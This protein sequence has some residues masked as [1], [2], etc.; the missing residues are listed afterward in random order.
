[1]KTFLLSG[2]AIFFISLVAIGQKNAVPPSEITRAVYF[3]ISEPLRDFKTLT[4]E[5]LKQLKNDKHKMRNKTLQNRYYPYASIA[6]PKGPD[7]VWQKKMGD[8]VTGKGPIL[9]FNGQSTSSTPPDCNGDVGPNHYFQGVNSSYTIY[10]KTGTIVAGPSAYNSLFSGVPGSNNNDGDPIIL[11]DDQADRWMAAEFSGAY[12]NPDYMLI[13][14]STTGDPTGTWYRWSFIMQGFPDYMKF[15]IWQ[16]GYY[17]ATN[18]FSGNDVYVFEREVMLEG[19]ATPQKVGFNNP[20]RPTTLDG[21]HCIQ[22]LDND[23]VYAPDGSPGMFITTN[24]DAIGGGSDQL[25]IYELDV[26]WSS[27]NSSTF[28]RVQQLNVAAF[29]SNFGGSWNNILQQGTNQK[30]DAIPQILMYR[31]QYRNFGDSQT[32]VCCQ[33][34]DVDQSNHA[35][36]RWYELEKNGNDWSVRQQST[37]GP[38][39][40]S[41]WMGSIAINEN[42]EIAIGYSISS[43]SKYPGIR[44]VGQSA[45]ANALA[46]G[47]MDVEEVVIHEGTES[48]TNANR[49]GDYSL[50]TVDP[51]D[52][53]FWFTTQYIQGSKKTK[54]C[55]FDLLALQMPEAYAG[56]D[57]TICEDVLLEV[58]TA[59]AL[60]SNSVEWETDG[61]GFFQNANVINAKYLRGNGDIANGGVTLTLKVYGYEAGWEDS[62]DIYVTILTNP[63]ANAGSD[64]TIHMNHSAYLHGEP[65]D[66]SMVEWT[67]AGDG[68]FADANSLVTT[69]SPGSEDISNQSAQLT[70]NVT[71]ME[72]CEG[73]DSDY[74]TITID[75]TVGIEKQNLDLSSFSIIPNPSNGIFKIDIGKTDFE[76]LL[77]SVSN[78]TGSIVIEEL[79]TS[80]NIHQKKFDISGF[81]KGIYL[82]ELKTENY[83]LVK[84]III[85]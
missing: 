11:Y 59:S 69:Y 43:G 26:N 85:K 42:H 37:Y 52:N 38:D 12:S 66:Y 54:I 30:L 83:N 9:N 17:M 23:G 56:N 50:L 61:D 6:L 74:V 24:D 28:T 84:K 34:V 7:N 81:P 21:F 72:P 46:N 8:I 64:T 31:A 49:W 77:I 48:Q 76:P 51:T 71:A 45:E 80:E 68:T 73:Q 36:I 20:W 41:R 5:D 22:P 15:G 3:D 70:L 67:T 57:T 60:Y 47:L 40:H 63:D 19:G 78:L 29:D 14:V 75:P 79:L 44:Y 35:G 18:T 58:N 16:D 4:Q 55:A 32:I 10:N 33:T 82:V 39:D 25:W 2:W 53:T 65:G 62:D 1:M 13:A 27:P